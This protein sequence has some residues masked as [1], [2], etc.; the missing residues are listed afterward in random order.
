MG[1]SIER[2]T[3]KGDKQISRMR[4]RTKGTKEEIERR[5]PASAN[6]EY[7]RGLAFSAFLL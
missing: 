6:I 2:R 7:Y 1:R 5:T 3:P 4:M